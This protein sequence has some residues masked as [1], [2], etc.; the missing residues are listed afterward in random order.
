MLL[1]A[2]PVSADVFELVSFEIP[3]LRADEALMLFAQQADIPI[4]FP[5]ELVSRATANALVGEY[6]VKDGLSVLLEGTGLIATVGQRDQFV[7]RITASG[8]END[9]MNANNLSNRRRTARTLSGTLGAIVLAVGSANAPGQESQSAASRGAMLEEVVVTARRR[10]EDLKDVPVSI[11]VMNADYLAQ[12][13]ILDQWDL[14]AETPGIVYDEARDRLG[15]RPSIRGVS[16]EAQNFL[17]QKSGAFLDGTPLLGN[18]GS[19]QFSGVERIEVLR[20]PQSAAFGRAT[21][22]GAVNY[23]SKDPGDEFNSEFKL[24]TSDLGR[25]TASVSLDGPISDTLGFTFDAVLDEFEGPDTW[26]SSEGIRLGTTSSDYFTGKLKFTPNDKFD[27]EVRLLTL[28]TDDGQPIE[29]YISQAERDRCSNMTLPSGQ[30]YINGDFNCNIATATP[31][32]GVPQNLHPEETFTPDTPDYYLVQTYS[33][34]EP[35]SYTNRDRIQAEFNFSTDN[36]S[37]LQILTS[38]NEE[39]SRRWWDQ[40]RSSAIPVVMG[41]M[42]VGVNSMANPM[43]SKEKYLDLRWQSPD[44]NSVRWQIG[45]SW[46][47]YDFRFDVH[48][49]YAGIVL[50]LEDEANN[51]QPFEPGTRASDSANNLG[52]YGGV[53]WDITDRTT[54][55]IEGRFQEDSITSTNERT[56]ATFE[57]VTE[58]FQPRLAVNQVLSESWSLYGQASSGTNPAGVNTVFVS[59]DIGASLAAANTAGVISYDDTTF[60]AYDE[61][62]LTNF[63][64]GLKGRALDNRLQLTAALYVMKW[65]DRLGENSFDWMGTDPDPDTGLCTGI[66]RCW[67][68]GTYSDGT[69]FNLQQTASGNVVIPSGDVDLQ[70]IELEGAYFLN[71]HWSFRGALTLSTSRFASFC[72]PQPVNEF[73]YTPTFTQADGALTDCVDVTGNTITVEPTRSASLMASYYAPLGVGGWNW[74]GRVNLRYANEQYMDSLNLLAIPSTMQINSSVSFSNDNWDLTVFGN[75]LTNEDAPRWIGYNG[76]RNINR[77][78]S[79]WNYFAQLRIPREIG[80]RLSYRF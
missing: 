45:T 14:F 72:D 64:I 77:N 35:G 29:S 11:S 17:S 27:M 68:D 62:K 38:Y 7:L 56:G 3:V 5:Y 69:I 55:S 57:S 75:N 40:D 47:A 79:E 25:N 36:G 39:E 28:R 24:S 26:T 2:R 8:G 31:P 70:G 1:L 61:E 76:D 74:N 80:A 33:V 60:L 22:S 63:E 43:A 44:D 34:L 4:L 54:V 12:A 59:P 71:D 50:G 73:G 78:Q 51:G 46:F 53:T 10:E 67:N 48:S 66:A 15:G 9:D 20:G 19:L 41:T 52:L 13:G 58:S 42:A 6:R 49:Q 30:P 37:V 18:T 65:E 23:V 21:F 32:T 16:T